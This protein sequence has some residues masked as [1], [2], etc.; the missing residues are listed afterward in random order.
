MIKMYAIFCRETL[1]DFQQN[2]G[3]LAAQAGHAYLHAWWDAEKRLAEQPYF[4]MFDNGFTKSDY[5]LNVMLPYKINNDA[6][7]IALVV[8]TIDELK[9]LAECTEMYVVCHL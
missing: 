2:E 9:I 1:K 8:D 7:K 4:T 5:F 6:R 3:K